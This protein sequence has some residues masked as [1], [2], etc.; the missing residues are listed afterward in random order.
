MKDKTRDVLSYLS[1]KSI[2]HS[3]YTHYSFSE[4]EELQRYVLNV[5]RILTRTFNVK[6]LENVKVMHHT[7][8]KRLKKLNREECNERVKMI[9]EL[10]KTVY[11]IIEK[12]YD[13]F[14]SNTWQY[15]KENMKNYIYH[16]MINIIKFFYE[17]E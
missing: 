11:V 14:T 1:D 9:N 3:D 4:F 5:L 16:N 13:I 8:R 7:L 12:L 2:K 17:L 15:D 10:L 6:G